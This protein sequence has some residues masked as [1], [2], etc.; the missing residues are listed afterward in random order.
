MPGEKARH[1]SIAWKRIAG[2]GNIYRHKYEDVAARYV[3]ETVERDLPSLRVV[4]VAEANAAARG[5]DRRPE[6]R[7]AREHGAPPQPRRF[8]N[9]KRGAIRLGV[10]VFGKPVLPKRLR[11]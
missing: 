4:I 10:A 3:W 2:A 1:P 5:I 11:S 6:R 7:G 9:G 8:T